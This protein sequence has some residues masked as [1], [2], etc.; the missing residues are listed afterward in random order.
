MVE[1]DISSKGCLK[2]YNN[3]FPFFRKL[4]HSPSA[5]PL[6]TQWFHYCGSSNPY[7]L[8]YSSA[9][10]CNGQFDK[11]LMPLLRRTFMARA[12]FMGAIVDDPSPCQDHPI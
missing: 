3:L 10:I 7:E 11:G 12:P 1:V 2:K 9:L 4:S 8:T 6:P 5:H